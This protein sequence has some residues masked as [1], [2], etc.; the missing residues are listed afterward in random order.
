M[1]KISFD[2]GGVVQRL[3]AMQ[4]RMENIPSD[5]W[6]SI[7]ELIIESVHQNFLV[8]GRP[9]QWVE[10]KHVMSHSGPQIA[11][12]AFTRTLIGTG[13][14]MNSEKMRVGGNFVEVT[15]GEGLPY[16]KI[17]QFGGVIDQT[18]TDQQR[19]FFWAKYYSSENEMFKA[20]ALSKTLH[21]VI[22]QRRY[23][24]IQDEDLIEI[25]NYLRNYIINNQKYSITI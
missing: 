3:T 6:Q 4:L 22:P 11:E 8:G 12:P 9:E 13:V 7:G 20:M 24:R 2:N 5:I 16:A 15:W 23:L 25:T 14:L 1:F 21:I 18:I 19:R 10:S 17:H